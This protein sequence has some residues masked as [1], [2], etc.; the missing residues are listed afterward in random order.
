MLSSLLEDRVEIGK[1]RVIILPN[2]FL[3]LFRLFSGVL[4]RNLVPKNSKINLIKVL[5]RRIHSSA[6]RK[7]GFDLKGRSQYIVVDCK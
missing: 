5:F 3:K 4:W 2:K 6:S 7:F 1:S